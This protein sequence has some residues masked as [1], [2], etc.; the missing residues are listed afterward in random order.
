MQQIQDKQCQLS[1][2]R[3]PCS[4]SGA[5]HLDYKSPGTP[6]RDC[7]AQG[8]LRGQYR[9]SGRQ[10]PPSSYLFLATSMRGFRQI[11]PSLV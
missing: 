6:T 3:G 10:I 8:S 11:R 9:L 2:L 5:P 4:T 7:P 1:C